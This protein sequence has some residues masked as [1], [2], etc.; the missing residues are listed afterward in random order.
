MNGLNVEYGAQRGISPDTLRRYCTTA[1]HWGMECIAF[2]NEKGGY[3]LRSFDTC[4]RRGPIGVSTPLANCQTSVYVFWDFFD[5]L[6]IAELRDDFSAIVLNWCL[7]DETKAHCV[8]LIKGYKACA[9]LLPSLSL[10]D[11]WVKDVTEKAKPTKVYDYR[12]RNENHQT[13]N[14]F[15]TADRARFVEA[16]GKR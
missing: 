14:D 7:D 6:S 3:S 5:F 8:E 2:E 10:F 11:K 15:L 12:D 13:L 1:D 9:I 16:F 4:Y